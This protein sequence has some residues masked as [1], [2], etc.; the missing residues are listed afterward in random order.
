M[1]DLTSWCTLNSSSEWI[2]IMATNNI[3]KTAIPI[4]IGTKFD[5]FVQL[6]PDLQ[7]TIVTQSSLMKLFLDCLIG[8]V[9]EH[10]SMF[11]L[12]AIDFILQGAQ[13][14]VVPIKSNSRR[15][16][17]ESPIAHNGCEFY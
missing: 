13:N 10:K 8:T 2:N 7:W 17:Q 4:L 16:L 11:L 14:L 9:Q 5:D 3:M 1:F 12:E 15:K 6:L